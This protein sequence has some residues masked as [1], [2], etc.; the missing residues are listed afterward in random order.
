MICKKENDDRALQLVIIDMSF[1]SLR[2]LLLLFLWILLLYSVLHQVS[3][4]LL[5]CPLSL[6]LSLH[7]PRFIVDM[8]ISKHE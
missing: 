3:F 7:H 1:L 8:K 2:L 4:F 6:F 5:I